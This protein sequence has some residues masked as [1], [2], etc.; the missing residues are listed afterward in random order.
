MA[1]F[2]FAERIVAGRALPIFAEGKLL[3]DFTYI[4]DIVEGV[5]RIAT[6]PAPPGAAES[7]IFNIGNHRP[8]SVLAFVAVLSAALGREATLEFLPMQ[9]GDVRATAADVTRLRERVGFQPDTRLE[10]GLAAFVEWFLDWKARRGATL[11]GLTAAP[12]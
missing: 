7:E 4:D 12:P 3:R 5:V 6:A 11:P 1:Y 8:V 10:D 9:P 2:A